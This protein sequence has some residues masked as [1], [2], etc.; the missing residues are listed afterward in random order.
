M[1]GGVH[2]R[3]AVDS[4]FTIGRGICQESSDPRSAVVDEPRLARRAIV[5]NE[6]TKTK[7]RRDT[8]RWDQRNSSVC[9]NGT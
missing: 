7:K 2:V 4:V 6:K 9:G 8:T 5:A 3:Y 1:L